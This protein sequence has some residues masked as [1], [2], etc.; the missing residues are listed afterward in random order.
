MNPTIPIPLLLSV[1]SNIPE[2]EQVIISDFHQEL[3]EHICKIYDILKSWENKDCPKKKRLKLRRRIHELLCQIESDMQE[4][5]VNTNWGG[6]ISFW[7]SQCARIRNNIS[8][9]KQVDKIYALGM[10]LDR[11]FLKPGS[12]RKPLQPK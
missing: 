1:S 5:E 2:A 4:R 8:N 3:K 9:P 6:H 10:E 12:Y 11:K 7:T